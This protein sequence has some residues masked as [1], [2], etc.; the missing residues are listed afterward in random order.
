MRKKLSLLVI[1]L[2]AVVCAACGRMTN[3]ET[4]KESSVEETIEADGNTTEIPNEEVTE[5]PTEATVRENWKLEGLPAYEGENAL[6]KNVYNGGTG[7][8]DLGQREP[9]GCQMQVV[10]ETDLE[11]VAAYA[12][13][14]Q[15]N[16]YELFSVEEQEQ[17]RFYRLRAGER[18]VYLSY[19]GV[20]ERVNIIVD[21]TGVFPEEI[22]YTYE[23]AE[24]ERAE[25]YCYGIKMDPDGMNTG[26]NPNNSDNYPNNGQLMVIKCADNSVIIVDG[27]NSVQMRAAEQKEF[28]RF[29]HE[30]TETAEGER[31][32]ISAWF[33][34]H[35]HSDHFRGVMDFLKKYGEYYQVERLISNKPDFDTIDGGSSYTL[36]LATLFISKYPDCKE[37]KLHTGEKVQI[38][39]ITLHALYSHED[40]TSKTAKSSI[41]DFNDTTLV[42]RVNDTEG[43]E[44]LILGDINGNGEK[45]LCSQYGP[46]TLKSDIVQAAHHNFNY[47]TTSYDYAEAA[48]AVF[49]QS[50][51]GLVKNASSKK[52][53]DYVKERCEEWFCTGNETVGFA[54]VD[55]QVEVIYQEELIFDPRVAKNVQ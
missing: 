12:V 18:K 40:N 42:V 43:M 33:L 51:N 6:G 7:L 3:I 47:L 11:E 17:N 13:L 29:L 5:A 24:G 28:D 30:I 25:I 41:V 2:V 36:E 34:T 48:Y 52:N 37:V 14:L 27:A 38:A 23:P 10:T 9:D 32:R 54:V 49:T 46:S 8:M 35:Y 22:S 45:I 20:K 50:R 4:E 16:G 26:K 55:G 21:D 39:D 53:S 1:L 15:E 44:M 31:I 19:F